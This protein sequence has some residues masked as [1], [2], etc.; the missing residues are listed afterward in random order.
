[1]RRAQ[2]S[3]GGG[4]RIFLD[5]AIRGTNEYSSGRSVSS[6]WVARGEG[7]HQPVDGVAFT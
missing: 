4:Y 1:M 2:I 6:I 3:E 7:R 5:N